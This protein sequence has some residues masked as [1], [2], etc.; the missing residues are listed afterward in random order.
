MVEWALGLAPEND[1]LA[2]CNLLARAG[3][4]TRKSLGLAVSM[5]KAFDH[6]ESHRLENAER[7]ALAGKSEYQGVVGRRQ[8]FSG[9]RCEKIILVNGQYGSTGIHKLVDGSGNQFT[10]FA[11][12]ST[13]WMREG[14]VADVTG[15]VKSHEEYKGVKQTVLTR[16]KVKALA[17]S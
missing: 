17:V 12:G 2:N 5:V 11:S 7:T 15:T 16:C 14:D 9:L 8:V 1:Y 6:A 10:W 4:C 13:E 3:Y